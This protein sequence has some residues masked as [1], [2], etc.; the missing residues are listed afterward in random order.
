MGVIDFETN[1]LRQQEIEVQALTAIAQ[2]GRETQ[3]HKALKHLENIAYPL[4]AYND[5]Q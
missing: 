5:L 3:K 4:E 2:F 1:R